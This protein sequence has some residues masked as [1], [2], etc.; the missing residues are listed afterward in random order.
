M[1]DKWE[2]YRDDQGQWR[3]RRHV[4]NGH[5]VD[6]ATE[7]NL[8]RNDLEKV[9]MIEKKFAYEQAL[10]NDK[11]RSSTVLLNRRRG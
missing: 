7:V 11:A 10:V 2:L 8:G 5:F 3:C 4:P 6:A 9:E 1:D